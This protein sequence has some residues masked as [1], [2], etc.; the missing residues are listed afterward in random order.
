MNTVF[1]TCPICSTD[2][3]E[4]EAHKHSSPPWNLKACSNCNFLYLEEVPVYESFSE[5]FAWEKQYTALD[6]AKKAG[7][8]PFIL[9]LKR[10]FR[11]IRNL[12]P[13]KNM[14]SLVDKFAIEGRVVDLGCGTGDRLLA[15]SGKYTPYGIEISKHLSG[16]ADEILKK[17][18]GGCIHNNCIDGLKEAGE[19][20]FSAAILRS[21]LEHEQQPGLLLKEAHRALQNGGVIIVKVPNY[22]SINRMVMG[23]KW[24]G[25]RFPDHMNYF[26]PKSLKQILQQAGFK[27][28]RFSFTDSFP[29]N[30]NMW[31]IATKS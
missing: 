31:I 1:R 29:L 8:S 5:D 9:L 23:R 15:M 19:G 12:I 16:V 26:T 14:A 24:C 17:R 13:H 11:K 10:F 6:E 22:S 7:K 25:F 20:F 18:G 30:D 3:A 21:F 4:K 28:K 27:I 2:N